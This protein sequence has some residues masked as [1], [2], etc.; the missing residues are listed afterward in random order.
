MY[1]FIYNQQKCPKENS[2]TLDLE[3]LNMYMNID[4]YAHSVD[5]TT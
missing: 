1:F 4:I 3:L 5:I 2:D